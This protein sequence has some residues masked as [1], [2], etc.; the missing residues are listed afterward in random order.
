MLTAEQLREQLSYNKTTGLFRYRRQVGRMKK[1]AVAGT[2]GTHG[3][4]QIG[5]AGKLY[6]ASRLAWLYVTGAWP[7]EIV[8]HKNRRR[9]DDR[10][11]NLR[12]LSKAENQQNCTPLRKNNKSGVKGVSWCSRR[13]RWQAHIQYENR[14]KSIGVFKTIREA[15]AA[16]RAAA[17]QLHT[18]RSK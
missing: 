5:V 8:D 1:G 16:Y 7:T 15:A 12:L 11:K 17:Q 6:K 14:Q 3:Y 10:W 13:Q 9:S 18:H 4:V 2:L